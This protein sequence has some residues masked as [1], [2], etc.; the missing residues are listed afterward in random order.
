MLLL[1]M[2]L[3]MSVY[4]L[5][6]IVRSL[7][8]IGSRI[9]VIETLRGLTCVIFGGLGSVLPNGGVMLVVSLVCGVTYIATGILTYWFP[10][11]RQTGGRNTTL[12]SDADR[13]LL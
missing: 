10:S 7:K 8:R 11:G 9:G 13:A 5:I 6:L 12:G 4:G 3:A 2:Y 1:G